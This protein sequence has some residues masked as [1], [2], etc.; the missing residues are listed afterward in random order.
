[1]QA[2]LPGEEAQYAMA[3]VNR[4]KQMAFNIND[5]VPRKSAVLALL[6]PDH[7]EQT[8]LL[9]MKRAAGQ[10]VHSGQISFPGGQYEPQD[11][12]LR[13]T[14]LREAHEELGLIS[15]QIKIIGRL[16]PIYISPSNF[17]VIPFVGITFQ[18]PV[19]KLNEEVDKVLIANIETLLVPEAKQTREINVRNER[20]EV[21]CFIINHEIVWGATAMMINEL[22]TIIGQSKQ[23]IFSKRPV[24]K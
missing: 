4:K 8:A 16:T 1:M 15:S 24:K 6:F 9:L 17:N 20:L 5:S 12:D 23:S 13:D 7:S 3:P 11:K 10:S 2:P 22:L 21:P 19:I 18:K 14:A